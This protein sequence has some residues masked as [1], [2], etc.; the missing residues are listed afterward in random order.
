MR[1]VLRARCEP[2]ALMLALWAALFTQARAQGMETLV[3]PGKV[4]AA[5]AKYEAD[6]KS[7][8]LAFKKGEQNALCIECH[9][10]VGADI[11]AGS[12]FHGRDRDIQGAQ[13]AQCHAEH[14][15]READIV[16]LD[17]AQ[18]DHR[19]TDF[20][21]RGAHMNL[22]CD[23]CHASGKK[24]REAPGGCVDCHRDDDVHKGELGAV[25]TDCHDERTWKN[26]TFDHDTTRFRLLGKHRATVC[27]DCHADQTFQGAPMECKGCHEKDD[28]HKGRNGPKCEQCHTADDWKTST[29]NHTRDTTFTLE[30]A[31]ARLTCDGCHSPDPWHDDLPRDCNGCHRDDDEHRG[32][33]GPKCE[34]CHT[35]VK[36]TE[37]TFDHDRDTRY[38]LRGAHRPLECEACHVEPIYDVALPSECYACHEDDDVHRGDEGRQCAQCHNESSWKEQVAFDHGLAR[39]PLLGAHAE[40]TCNACHESQVFKDAPTECDSCHAD[41]DVHKGHL[42]RACEGCHNPL[43]WNAWTFDHNEDTDFALEGAHASVR[44]E[45]CH[46]VPLESYEIVD[47]SCGACHHKDDVHRG[48]FGSDCERCHTTE[49]FSAF[50]G[51]R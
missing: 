44:C 23:D 26:P 17:P 46:D 41:D 34:S 13:C 12:G 8:H 7:C 28:V 30:G 20:Q 35:V 25:C 16:H 10:A 43:A 6:C 11:K 49:S 24:F 33:N 5:H 4:A 3:M 27:L 40:A 22:K 29:F 21:L 37:I 9:R 50:R 15:G 48:E 18:V 2:A 45:S 38:P 51:V 31:H 14:E 47:R 32:H 1:K 42:G 36:W 19:V 39:F